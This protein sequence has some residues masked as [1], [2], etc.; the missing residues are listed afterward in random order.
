MAKIN[1]VENI[2]VTGANGFIGSNLVR[3]LIEEGNNVRSL[4]R[5]TSDLSFIEN[6]DTELIFGDLN[7]KESLD[8]ATKKIDKVYHVAGLAADWGSYKKFEQINYNGT[9]NLAISAN[10]NKVKKLVYISTVAFHGFGKINMTEESPIA[11]NLIPYAK[12]KYLAEKWLWDFHKNNNIEIAA[13]R[14]GN[15][16]GINDRTFISKYIDALLAGKFMQVNNGKSKTCPV[17]IENLIDII[18]LVG[19]NDKANGHAFIATDG[20]DIDWL[21]FNAKLADSLGIKLPKASIPYG[22][23]MPIAKIYY[24]LHKLLGFKS[25]PFLTPYRINNGGKDYHFSIEKL[26]KFFNYKPKIDIDEAMKR[27]VKW[28]NISRQLNL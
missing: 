27:T 15:V 17:Y 18:L 24:S 3:R 9:K 8:K 4:V 13:V 6:L 11:K 16:Y 7:D 12:T 26:Q 2:L 19:N 10:N 21:T 1:L 5:K 28:Y 25:E 22:L 14:P 23:A 20:L